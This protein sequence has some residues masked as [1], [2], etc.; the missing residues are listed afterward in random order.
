MGD[1]DR[2]TALVTG[3][4]SGIGARI[5]EVL[6]ADGA[7]VAIVDRDAD[8]AERVA[9]GLP[10]A[11]GM[12][13]DVSVG[14]DVAAMVA[15]LHAR[16]WHPDVVVNNA[17]TC[18]DL[19]YEEMPLDAW[20]RDLDVSLTGAFLVTR[21][22]FPDLRRRGGSVVN[23]ASVNAARAF[24]NEAYSAA[25]AGLVS[26][27][28]GLAVRWAPHRVR[29]NAVLP[30]T[31]QTPIWADRLRRD[32]TALE[33]AAAMYPLGRVGQPDDVAQAVLF[34]TSDRAAWI[35]GVALP[36]DGGLLAV[37][38]AAFARTVEHGR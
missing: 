2:R 11:L 31:V 33:R 4:G 7:R 27:T 32:P 20:R 25:K 24:G 3:G 13:A 28:Q 5:A 12:R 8:A 19:P 34:L 16:G 23:I 10:G 30:G 9:A 36:V 37:G 6:S 18:S 17:A 21:D 26:L 35:T 38:S 22:L 15:E 1:A 14:A 29:V